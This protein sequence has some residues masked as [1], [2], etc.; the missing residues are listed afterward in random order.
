VR[1]AFEAWSE[2]ILKGDK[3]AR[4]RHCADPTTVL[5]AV[6]GTEYFN[7]VGPG[8]CD[9]RQDGYTRWDPASDRR[10]YYNVQKIDQA[11]LE[12]VMNDLLLQKPGRSQ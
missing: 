6:R 11:G 12:E 7:E 10:Q 5:Y 2:V 3:V 4:D 8:S 1:V 9:V